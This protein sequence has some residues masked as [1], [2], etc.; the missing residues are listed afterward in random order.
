MDSERKVERKEIGSK[1]GNVIETV[2]PLLCNRKARLQPLKV[3]SSFLDCI[4]TTFLEFMQAL[5]YP[6]FLVFDVLPNN[7]IFWSM[8]N[9]KQ[10]TF[11]MTT[12]INR[13]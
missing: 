12:S 9:C 10:G 5:L 1:P 3:Q 13:P 2:F 6:H 8:V 4:L 7:H 11:L